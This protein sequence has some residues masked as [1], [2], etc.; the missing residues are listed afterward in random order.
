MMHPVFSLE[1]EH[2][3]FTQRRLLPDSDDGCQ[4]AWLEEIEG[5]IVGSWEGVLKTFPKLSNIGS[6][7][8]RD[9][10]HPEEPVRGLVVSPANR[11]VMCNDFNLLVLETSL[12]KV[13]WQLAAKE[14]DTCKKAHQ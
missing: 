5:L 12:D 10:K 8:W 14:A 9:P 4:L 3:V 2:S 1:Q 6:V 13:L 7:V 11:V